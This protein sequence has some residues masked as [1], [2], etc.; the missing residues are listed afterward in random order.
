MTGLEARGERQGAR[1]VAAAA[2]R[3]ARIAQE[4]VPGDVRV[5]R[6]GATVVL[7]GR[8]LHVRSIDDPRLRG[9]G[10]LAGNGR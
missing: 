6:D 1:A 10:L 8:S 5:A 7:S 4:E 2:E 3:I 9:F